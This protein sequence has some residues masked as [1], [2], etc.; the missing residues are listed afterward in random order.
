MSLSPRG[1]CLGLCWA[2]AGLV[3]GL[4]ACVPGNPF[5][6]AHPLGRLVPSGLRV[7]RLWAPCP[8][9]RASLGPCAPFCVR[10]RSGCAEHPLG[11]PVPSRLPVVRVRCLCA[12]AEK[13]L[14]VS[15]RY[16]HHLAE[17]CGPSV[18]PLGP[19]PLSA[20]GRGAGAQ[21]IRWDA[22]CLRGFAF[23]AFGRPALW[24][25]RPLGPA[26]LSA[27]ARGAGAQ[28]IPGVCSYRGDDPLRGNVSQIKAAL[29]TLQLP[30]R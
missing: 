27:Y 16:N 30:W 21:D 3:L 25:V 1:L 22:R 20:Y 29:V 15:N 24:P 28:N 13:L 5:H 2:C 12:V 23:C 17:C 26:P 9:A 10:P 6:A 18:R 19:A 8:L 4:W 11:R 7:L 14:P